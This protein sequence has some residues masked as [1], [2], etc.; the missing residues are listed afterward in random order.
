VNEVIATAGQMF[1]ASVRPDHRAQLRHDL[2]A[3]ERE[4]GR[5][6]EAIATCAAVIPALMNRLRKTE[7]KR[8]DLVA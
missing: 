8:R 2:A 5:L 7:A 6:T 1:E 3:V 4:Q